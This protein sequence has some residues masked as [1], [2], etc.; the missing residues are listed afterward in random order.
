[1]SLSLIQY[2]ILKNRTRNLTGNCL[3]FINLRNLLL[4]QYLSNYFRDKISIDIHKMSYDL[5][6]QLLNILQMVN[7]IAGYSPK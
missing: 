6:L 5:N 3:R 1:M 7:A 4:L 2:C